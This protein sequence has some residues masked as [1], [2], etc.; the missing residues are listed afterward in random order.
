MKRTISLL[1]AVAC[2]ATIIMTGTPAAAQQ[3]NFSVAPPPITSPYFEAGKGEGK[4]RF[5][6]LT[7]KGEGMELKGGG[8]DFVGRS[9][10]S[11]Y[12]AADIAFG[13]MFMNADFTFPDPLGGTST[14]TMTL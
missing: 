7:I 10:F 2:F 8:F 13:I 14:G 3:S 4:F 9:A 1:L 6:Y 5:T 11:E 12:L